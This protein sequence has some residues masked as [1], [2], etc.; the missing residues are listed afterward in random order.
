[1]HASFI[2]A[3]SQLS[4]MASSIFLLMI[5]F[6]LLLATEPT[7][8]ARIPTRRK[9]TGFRAPLTRVCS[10]TKNSLE[11]SLVTSRMIAFKDDYLL[12]LP[13]LFSAIMD[14]GSDLIW[15][16]CKSSHDPGSFDPSKSISFVE[17][18]E[19]CEMLG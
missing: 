19:T 13:K 7:S 9:Q 3:P 8:S 16:K 6:H 11:A 5:L 15:T 10:V 18:N 12:S 2:L 17:I 1:M 14:T 4:L